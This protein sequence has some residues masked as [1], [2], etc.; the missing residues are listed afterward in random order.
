MTKYNIYN[1]STARRIIHSGVAGAKHIEILPRQSIENVEL[2]DNVAENLMER[3]EADPDNELKLDIADE[4]A[5]SKFV[6]G[7]IKI[8][9]SKVEVVKSKANR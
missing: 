3:H 6:A 5:G 7:K 8:D 9:E 2:S 4:A 1:P